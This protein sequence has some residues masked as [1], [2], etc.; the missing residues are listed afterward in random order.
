VEDDLQG[1]YNATIDFPDGR[2]LDKIV[3]SAAVALTLP[4]SIFTAQF[5]EQIFF[6][7]GRID[8]IQISLQ[9][10]KIDN[11]RFTTLEVQKANGAHGS[12]TIQQTEEVANLTGTWT[13][14][15]SYYIIIDAEYYSDGS[16]HIHYEVYEPPY[17]EGDDPIL[18]ADYDISPD[19]SGEGTITY[20]DEVYQITFDGST[21]AELSKGGK[22]AR[23]N[24]YQ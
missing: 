5:S 6:S 12:F 7:S 17:N 18:I 1:W 13:T 22:K 16:A 4:D 15:N 20:K 8:T 10:Q 11:I 3:K 21:D 9:S 24:L 2:Y 14:W 23:I 19:G